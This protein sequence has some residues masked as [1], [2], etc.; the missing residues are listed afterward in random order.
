MYAMKLHEQRLLFMRAKE[1][2]KTLEHTLMVNRNNIRYNVL[3]KYNSGDII[4]EFEGNFSKWKLRRFLKTLKGCPRILD[5]IW[6]W[7]EFMLKNID[8]MPEYLPLKE[9][10]NKTVI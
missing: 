7:R 9:I 5:S 3:L 4:A 6:D 8:S 2:K 1:N 10:T